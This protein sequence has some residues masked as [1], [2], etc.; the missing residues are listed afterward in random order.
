MSEQKTLCNRE[1]A[2]AEVYGH[3]YHLTVSSKLCTLHYWKH[4]IYS[5]FEEP[6][7]C[8]T[9]VCC[10]CITFGRNV[11]KLD[12]SHWCVC[13]FAYLVAINLGFVTCLSCW[14][15]GRTRQSRDLK[16]MYCSMN[17]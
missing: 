9:T 2:I 15:R 5:C 3:P 7:L 13:C 10:P 8:A 14:V 16:G 17:W 12:G 1:N 6:L 11:E 4:P